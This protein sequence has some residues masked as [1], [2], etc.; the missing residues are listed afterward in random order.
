MSFLLKAPIDLE[1]STIHFSV[2]FNKKTCDRVFFISGKLSLAI[3]ARVYIL[4]TMI[5][6]SFLYHLSNFYTITITASGQAFSQRNIL[7][8]LFLFLCCFIINFWKSL[9]LV[10]FKFSIFFILNLMFLSNLHLLGSFWKFPT[11]KNSNFIAFW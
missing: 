5:L 1:S 11:A 9:W 2:I 7:D 3:K 8:G 6:Y 4:L 10:M